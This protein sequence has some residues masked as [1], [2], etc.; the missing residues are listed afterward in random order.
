MIPFLTRTGDVQ[1]DLDNLFHVLRDSEDI[2]A[3]PAVTAEVA[4][5]T[6]TPTLATNTFGGIAVDR[7]DF[8]RRLR[9]NRWIVSAAG[10]VDTGDGNGATLQLVYVRD[11]GTFVVLGT[12]V[13][14][15]GTVSKMTFG[16]FDVF[17]TV[18][19]PAGEQIPVVALTAQKAS[20]AN[21][22][23]FVWDVWLRL[24]PSKS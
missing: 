24:L 2:L 12:L 22:V 10:W 5:T 3:F 1:R 16:P 15:G 21:G 8:R 19:V 11:N 18:G 20:G 7:S 6:A 4:F 14:P 9:D 23:L 17:A 13:V